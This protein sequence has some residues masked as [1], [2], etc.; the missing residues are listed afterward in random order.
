MNGSS[1]NEE[2]NSQANMEES[3]NSDMF[4][5]DA[6]S[7][8]SEME[9]TTRVEEVP[10]QTNSIFRNEHGGILIYDSTARITG[11]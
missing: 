5:E 6:E 11:Q 10:K 9:T 1:C 3:S 8:G 4:E 7:S 2:S